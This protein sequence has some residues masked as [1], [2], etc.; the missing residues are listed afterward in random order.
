MNFG[1]QI[2]FCKASSSPLTQRPDIQHFKQET[3]PVGCMSPAFLIPG[4]GGVPGQR[5]PARS[6]GPGTETPPRR[7]M[8]P[9]Q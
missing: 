3:I 6:K 8:A 4:R 5:P 7:N 9:R 2:D 1:H